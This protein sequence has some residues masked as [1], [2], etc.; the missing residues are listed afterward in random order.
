MPNLSTGIDAY[1]AYTGLI[2]N[3]SSEPV[4]YRIEVSKQ[5]NLKSRFVT[6][7]ATNNTAQAEMLWAG[8]NIGL[9]YRARLSKNDQVISTK[10]S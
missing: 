6:R 7:N 1:A 4:Y 5:P 3:K 2:P 8:L 9:G 10:E